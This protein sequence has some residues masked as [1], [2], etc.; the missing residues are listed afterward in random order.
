MRGRYV[1]DIED[2]GTMS[3][4]LQLDGRLYLPLSQRNEIAL[5]LFFGMADGNRPNIYA[6]GGLDTIRGF[7]VRS[8]A[9]NRAAFTNIE[10]RFPLIDRL[11]MPFLRLREVRGRFFVDIGAAWWDTDD[12]EFNYLGE[13]G[14]Q[15]IGEKTLP[16]GTVV[17]ESGRLQDGVASYGFG[18][19]INLFGLPMH[20]DFVKRWDFDETL[21]DTEVDFW[22]GLQF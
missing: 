3:Q 13:P 6:F 5:R 2:G 1:Y 7:R 20:W 15:F 8:L 9:G 12:G 21:G 16:D 4:D 11:E 19:T 14:F 18:L 22:I 17:G 10:W